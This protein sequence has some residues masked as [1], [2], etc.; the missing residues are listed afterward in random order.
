M[1]ITDKILKISTFIDLLIFCIENVLN[2]GIM[3]TTDSMQ[4]TVMQYFTTLFTPCSFIELTR[5]VPTVMHKFNICDTKSS[6]VHFHCHMFQW[7]I[8]HHH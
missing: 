1:F 6:E 4:E 7:H 3:F 2:E 8:Y 5:K